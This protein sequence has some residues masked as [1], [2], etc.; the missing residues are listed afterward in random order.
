LQTAVGMVLKTGDA[1]P[2]IGYTV[3][4]RIA[5]GGLDAPHL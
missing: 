5:T 2:P 3:P 1:I 4:G